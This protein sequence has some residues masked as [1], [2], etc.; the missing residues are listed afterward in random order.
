MKRVL[1]IAYHFPP[2]AGSSGIQRTLRF[3]QHLPELGWEP[4]VL[5]AH[6][7]AYERV[8]DDLMAEVPAG[9]AVVR[10]FA[11][12][13]ARH[14]S[15]WGRYP[16]P[17][18]RPDRW[19]TWQFGA[20]MAGLRLVR[21]YSPSVIWSTYPIATAH[22]IGESVSRR[23]GLPWIAD[24]RD[25]MAQERYPTD[26]MVWQ[27][28]KRIEERAMRSARF[29]VF[30][31][32][33]AARVY[34]DQY[35]FAADRMAVIENGY[36]EESFAGVPR[37]PASGRS[38]NVGAFTLLHSGVVYPSERD[39]TQF[40]VAIRQLVESGRIRGGELVVRFRASCHDEFLRNLAR[41]HRV[42]AFIE[43][44][45]PLP[46]R[47]ALEEMSCADAL[48]VLQAADCNEQVPAKLYEYLRAGRPIVALTDPGGDTAGIL[49]KA[50]LDSVARLDAASEI[51]LALERCLSAAAKGQAPLPNPEYVA[52]A[53]RRRRA[54]LLAVLLDRASTSS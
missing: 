38:L 49:R 17:L 14:L 39:P 21:D 37:D 30:T 48:L 43:L 2:L 12:D 3:V 25:P 45:P 27:S 42:E 32:P 16:S 28:Y 5:T 7:R 23:S 53:T 51:A 1:M 52:G 54:E 9:V 50:G 15:F 36:D 35:A 41:Q 31:T 47:V 46:Y 6:P 26:P 10:A 44:L 33:G 22:I 13:A 18:A 29:N 8:S 20:T 34:A 4:V 24:F 40:F 19:M 11:L